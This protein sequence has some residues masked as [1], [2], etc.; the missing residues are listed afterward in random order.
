MTSV[1]LIECFATYQ[2]EGPDSGKSMLILRFK[3]CNNSC[4]WCD[5]R[6][7]MRISV[8]APYDLDTIQGIINMKKCGILVTGGEPT[9][10]DQFDDS[11][12]LLNDLEY[13]IANVESNGH[14]LYELIEKVDESK[15]VHYIYSPKI[16]NKKDFKKATSKTKDLLEA[17]SD[18]VFVKVVI[19][20]DRELIERYLSW[21]SEFV[22]E[23]NLNGNIWLMPEGTTRTDLI[24]NSAIVFD[25]CEKYKFNFSSRNH[26]IFGF[27]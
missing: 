11:L 13:P 24:R 15:N 5:T 22:D 10:L 25:L 4:P 3:R 27:V 18:R 6:V 2:G 1:N 12:Y 19:P 8:E 7:K 17:H 26:I 23:R 20:D 14:R 9:Y 16:F 21:L